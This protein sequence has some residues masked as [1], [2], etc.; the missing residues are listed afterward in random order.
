MK[1]THAHG[2][3]KPRTERRQGDR[4]DECG[5]FGTR[6]GPNG[7]GEHYSEPAAG[8]GRAGSVGRMSPSTHESTLVS[9]LGGRSPT[10]DDEVAISH[11][12]DSLDCCPRAALVEK[13]IARESLWHTEFTKPSCSHAFCRHVFDKRREDCLK[14]RARVSIDDDAVLLE[15]PKTYASSMFVISGTSHG[16][17]LHW[18]LNNPD[19]LPR[20]EFFL[21]GLQSSMQQIVITRGVPFRGC[22]FDYYGIP[23]D[24]VECMHF[25]DRIIGED[26]VFFVAN[27]C[28]LAQPSSQLSLLDK[29]G[30]SSVFFRVWTLFARRVTPSRWFEFPVR[31]E[32]ANDMQAHALKP[33]NIS[34]PKDSIDY[35]VAAQN[36]VVHFP[37]SHRESVTETLHPFRGSDV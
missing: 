3:E 16:L 1:H 20:C 37:T 34:R 14:S 7:S 19:D 9:D 6:E 10:L 8:S 17:H 30:V 29:S 24:E 28:L 21:E 31:M 23:D 5:S 2:R 4:K 26:N 13:D 35:V 22:I 15:T 33:F 11:S 12:C 32:V 25:T 27:P 36:N 18:L